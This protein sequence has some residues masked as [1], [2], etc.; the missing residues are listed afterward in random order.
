MFAF[1][2]KKLTSWW[3]QQ[4]TEFYSEAVSLENKERNSLTKKPI[5]AILP[6]QCY[7]ETYKRYPASVGKDIHKIAHVD[8][9]QISP[10]MT[11]TWRSFIII[12]EQQDYLVYYF[13]LLPKYQ[14]QLDQLQPFF[15][16]PQ[17][18]YPLVQLTKGKLLPSQEQSEYHKDSHG[19]WTSSIVEK[20][21]TDSLAE[22]F[23]IEQ[24]SGQSIRAFF[25]PQVIA[26]L[27]AKFDRWRQAKWLFC[28]AAFAS[29][30]L[31]SASLYLFAMDWYLTDKS[32]QSRPVIGQLFKAKDA[33]TKIQ[34]QQQEI[35]DIYKQSKEM[36]GPLVLIE[37]L[38]NE[39]DLTVK[40]ISI[41]DQQV[42]VQGTAN[43]ANALL[44]K[45]LSSSKVTEAGFR[46][47]IKKTGSADSTEKFELEF[48]WEQNLWEGL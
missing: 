9:G 35:A 14:A 7:F 39:F 5:V 47:D 30:Y 22:R 17:T 36:S 46:S 41:K 19:V 20:G 31:A 24:L 27:A 32:E 11:T 38:Q 13:V 44:E 48:Q 21:R 12:K 16:V 15:I 23:R 34:Q 10:Y 18:A 33:L 3:R 37:S 40:Q 42:R 1:F 43:N 2:N 25:N 26:Q 45:L 8:S 6:R 4:I 28:I 29:F